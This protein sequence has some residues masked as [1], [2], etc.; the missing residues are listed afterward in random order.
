MV[1]AAPVPVEL[2]RGASRYRSTAV[3]H[4]TRLARPHAW[5][6]GR[7]SALSA[8]AGDWLITDGV[9]EWTVEAD[10]FARTYRRLP[11]GRFA[12]DAPVDAVR[13]DRPLDVPTLEGVAR[14]EAGDWV[15]RGVDGELW[16]VSDA[17]FRS[18]YTPD[19]G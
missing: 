16:P 6:T 3:V 5:R 8:R 7:G 18:T 9:Q 2:L 14:A 12:K 17:Y 4:A 13:T 15:L 1:P 11:D 10:I 19:A